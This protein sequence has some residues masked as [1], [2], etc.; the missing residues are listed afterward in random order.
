MR[1]RTRFL[2]SPRTV[3]R[4]CPKWGGDGVMTQACGA[5]CTEALFSSSPEL[6]VS[7]ELK[8]TCLHNKKKKKAINSAG[9]RLS[10]QP[11]EPCRAHTSPETQSTQGLP[12]LP[13]LSCQP[14]PTQFSQSCGS[15]EPE[16]SLFLAAVHTQGSFI[17]RRVA[18]AAPSPKSDALNPQ[19]KAAA[20]CCCTHS[21]LFP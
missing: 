18:Q 16:H 7:H 15:A 5:A 19:C 20:S 6:A 8:C 10:T 9:A 14:F 12:G 2:H 17:S 1:R 4:A 21:A 13:C 3:A 11:T